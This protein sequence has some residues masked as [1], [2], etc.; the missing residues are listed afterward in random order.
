MIKSLLLSLVLAASQ[1]PNTKR[2]D[3]DAEHMSSRMINGKMTWILEKQ[4]KIIHPDGKI[5]AEKIRVQ[6][7]DQDISFLEAEGNPL[8]IHYQSQTNSTYDIQAREL[9]F[10]SNENTLRMTGNI[11]LTH[12]MQGELT[13]STITGH[14]LQAKL[15]GQQFISLQIVGK[16]EVKLEHETKDKKNNFVA[17]ATSIEFDPDNKKIKLDSV[18]ITRK[19]EIITAEHI[20][21]DPITGE[22]QAG[23][24]ISATLEVKE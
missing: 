11:V 6:R 21:I 13:R 10:N 18:K 17:T 19:G 1:A 9:F 8:K 2:F 5:V 12:N 3:I 24:K 15:Q 7:S 14:Q 4:A 23:S 22:I 16:P 20:V